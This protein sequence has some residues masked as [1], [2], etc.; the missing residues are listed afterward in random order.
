MFRRK[1]LAIFVIVLMVITALTGCS[2][3]GG[4]EKADT[5]IIGNIF[6]ADEEGRTVQALAIKDGIY[7]YAG[8][9][10]GVQEYIGDSTEV[11]RMEGGMAM[12]GFFDSHT[13]ASQ[14]GVGNLF[15]VNL[16][17]G[18]SMDEYVATVAEFIKAHPDQK[19]ITGAGWI[20]GYCPKGG[21]TKEALD[22][23]S[24][25]IP[26][27]IISGDHHSYWANSKALE[28]AGITAETPDIKGGVIERNPA[29]KEPTGTVRENANTLITAIIPDYTVE[30]YKQ[31][32]L[33]YQKEVKA[34]G[35]TAYFEPM[36]NINGGTNLLQAYNELDD[37]GKLEIRV[38]G[39]LQVLPDQ[40][41]LSY[42]DECV[43]LKQ[44]SENGNFEIN[45]VKIFAD[46]VVEGKTAYL[47]DEYASDPGLRGE[48]LWDQ[49]SLNQVCAKA[50]KLGLRIEAHAIGD[51]A[52]K[53][54]VD[55]YEYT[56][57]A[58]GTA[59][60]RHSITHLQIVDPADIERMAKL[61]VIASTNPYWFCKEPGYFYELEVP[62]LGED[63]ANREYPM[64]A[65]FDAGIKV[66]AAS[67][68]PVT[69][70]SMPLQAIQTGVTRCDR[71]GETETL[72]NPDQRV[73]VQQ[74]IEAATI[75]G[76][77]EN[78]ADEQ[79]GSIAVGKNA[80][81]ILLDQNLLDIDPF[82]ISKTT[83]Q[84]TISNG[85]TIYQK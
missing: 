83:V 66:T 64:K 49:E 1:G 38:F 17:E 54:I 28:M 78:F 58:N 13:H 63:R 80:D 51:A 14:G 81:L 52:V 36:V 40:N 33:E 46:G 18:T 71:F 23:I 6:T 50:D 26:I 39:G 65:F 42:L 21:P 70:P 84:R 35:I 59:D 56:A 82:D 45:A 32:I 22:Q 76:A 24:T 7:T 37:E 31:G 77:Y 53:M 79:I 75:N 57:E 5:V 20:N 15:E 61:N 12:P 27:A 62:Y 4:T 85:K 60:H 43:K 55:A 34:Y 44:E 48:P 3:T 2:S 73:T 11:I 8:E 30:Q 67:D 19:F 47:I 68:Y 9:E 69:I 72:Q 29:T 10:E 25:E 41:P 74:M 16:Y